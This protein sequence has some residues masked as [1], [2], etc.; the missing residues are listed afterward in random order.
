MQHEREKYMKVLTVRN[1]ALGYDKRII[2][3]NNVPNNNYVPNN[4]VPN[5]TPH[6]EEPKKNYTWI[7]IVVVVI[8]VFMI[9]RFIFGVVGGIFM[10]SS[11]VNNMYNL[12]QENVFIAEVQN[13]ARAAE[14]RFVKDSMTDLA[15]REYSRSN[16]HECN[17]EPITEVKEGFDYYIKFDKLGS[18]VKLQVKDAN[19]GYIYEGDRIR[20]EEISHSN[21]KLAS[22]V[23]IPA[24]E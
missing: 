23:S 20:V 7:L 1:L 21:I 3:D 2:M 13:I 12:A 5:N 15:E 11:E 22:D 18:I 24:C 16:G 9:G 6:Y 8:I 19:Y 17:E 14:I 4:N 10:A